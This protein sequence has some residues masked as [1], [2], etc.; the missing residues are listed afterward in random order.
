LAERDVGEGHGVSA[1]HPQ[2]VPPLPTAIPMNRARYSRKQIGRT[3]K[4]NGT[5]GRKERRGFGILRKYFLLG[6]VFILTAFGLSVYNKYMSKMGR[7]K[8]PAKDRQSRVIALRVTPAEY[9]KIERAAGKSKL[10]D[11]V[12]ECLGLRG[13]K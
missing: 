3:N 13:D 5:A 7:P 6:C 11:Y 10:G 2:K 1:Y 4:P 9:K 12:R 8:K